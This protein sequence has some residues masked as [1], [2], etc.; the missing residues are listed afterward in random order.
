MRPPLDGTILI[1]GASSGIGRAM[2]VELAPRAKALVLV[3]RRVDR[4]EELRDELVARRPELVVS[5]QQ[6]DLCER[7]ATDRMLEAVAREVGD[8]DVLI[9]NAGIGDMGAFD[10]AD[11][12]KTERLIRLNV[13]SLTYLCHRL[14][15]PM[16]ERRRGGILNVS[17][18]FGLEFMPSFATYIASKHYVSGLTESM[19]LDL[20]S[21]GVVVTQ[22]CPGPVA[23]EFEEHL[24]NFTGHKPPGFLEISAERCARSAIGGFARDRA[25]VIPGIAIRFVMWIGALTPR[26]VKR[27]IYRPLAG[28]AR[29]VQL[30]AENPPAGR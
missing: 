16:V 24:G 23:T 4:L 7:V 1:T 22:V 14:V 19:R 18:G 17:S 27:L 20:R 10:R 21:Q 13:E 9:N 29:R 6:C 12:S 3:A 28:A 25:L 11:W 30:R 15:G 5:L 8:V 26:W 2:A